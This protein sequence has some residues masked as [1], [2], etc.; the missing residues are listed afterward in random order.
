MYTLALD[1]AHLFLTIVL[2]DEEKVVDYYMQPCLKKQSESLISE[3]DNLLTKHHL[4]VN[5]IEKLV[6]TCGPG[7]YTGVRIAMTFAKVLGSICHKEVYTLSTL[8][9]YAG[10]KDSLVLLDARANRCYLARYC[11]GQPLIADC[12]KPNQQIK[13]MLDCGCN[14]VGDLHLF[15]LED[16]YQGVVDNF[17]QLKDKWVKVENIDLLTPVYL[18][19]NQEYLNQ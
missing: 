7:S 6:I 11:D 9:L 13:E 2:M 1:T 4:T 14:L 15:G 10:K 12:I 18:K 8:L 17:L 3:V 16:N 19:S 5:D